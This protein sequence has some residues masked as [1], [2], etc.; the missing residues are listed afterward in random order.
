MIGKRLAHY[1]I[2][3]LLGVGGMGEVYRARDTKLDREVALKLLPAN[4]AHDPER[5]ARFQR[6][7]RVLASLNHP[8]IAAIHGLE[9]AEGQSF[10]VMELA[11]GDDLS[12]RLAKGP[13]PLEDTLS[14]ALQLA[15]GLEEAHE[16]NIIHRDLKPANIM[17]GPDGKVKILD[18]GL[19]RAFAPESADAQDLENSPTIAAAMTQAGTILGTPAYM[20]PEQA[21]GQVADTRTDIWAFG[22]VMWECLTGK[23]LF[24]GRT[25]SD[26]IGAILRDEPDTET[27]PGEVPPRVRRLLRRCLAKEPERRLHH[28]ADVRIELEDDEENEGAA[29]EPSVARYRN[30]AF[31][32]GGVLVLVSGALI[33]Q[34]SGLLG[35]PTAPAVA[36]NPLSGATITRL[37]DFPGD[38]LKGAISPDGRFVAFASD[39]GGDFDLLIGQVGS[40][41]FRNVTNDHSVVMHPQVRSF[42]FSRDGSDIWVGRA[43]GGIRTTSLLGGSFRNFLGKDAYCVDWS[44]GGSRLVYRQVTGGDPVFVADR[45]GANSTLILDAPD[46]YHQHFPTWSADGEWIYLVRGWPGEA[47]LWRLRPD[48]SDLEQLTEDLRGIK[49]PTPVDAR[50]MLFSAQDRIGAG[51]WLW[52]FD[53]VT[54]VSRRISFGVEQYTSVAASGD[55]RRVV[56]TVA[57]PQAILW[58]VPIRDQVATEA[59]AAPFPLPTVRARCPRYGPDALF[60]LSSRG[61]GD[62]LWRY[63]DGEATEIWRGS[64]ATT[65]EEAPAVSPAGDFVALVATESDR[66]R[67]LI[68]GANGAE[69]RELPTG[70]VEVRGGISW[71]PDGRWLVVSGAEAGSP[72]LFKVPVDGG[73]P[74]RI[75]DGEARRPM[76]SP[77]GDFI[78]YAGAQ[79]GAEAPILAVRVDGT[80]VDLPETKVLFEQGGARARFLP[81]GSG[82]VYMKGLARLQDFYLLDL[83]TMQSRRLTQL[84]DPA[85]MRTFDVTPDG[86]EIVFDR[87]KRNSDLVLIE[88]ADRPATD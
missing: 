59:D 37:T 50:T 63:R 60:Y 71:S 69:R 40:R 6:E 47:D 13:L 61:A 81:D 33:A 65:L 70:E 4:L 39:R 54:G 80:P 2:T 31:A 49:S 27:L 75:V 57:D 83:A 43:E 34:W 1:E 21:R 18:F 20:S 86:S 58:R 41:D 46:G 55:G 22:C 42:G 78:V 67:I 85:E 32:L 62:E 11:E 56:A 7:A 73:E 12:V 5:L 24:G 15:A 9:E 72:G 52:M 74:T 38:E 25:A 17:I 51:P 82:L 77:R 87:L 36:A 68:L 19:A 28:I 26:S 8:N 23:T 30:A 48:G 10:L 16:K 35:S 29:P 76:W 66:R 44:P 79:V 53:A 88:L 45:D 64:G 3:D 84:E 14:L